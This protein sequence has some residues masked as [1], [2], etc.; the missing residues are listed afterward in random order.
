VCPSPPTR[1]LQ[2][3]ILS[4]LL[5]LWN[6]GANAQLQTGNLYGTVVDE[7]NVSLP[8]VTL[9][10]KDGG[11]PQVQVSNSQGQ[12]RFLS[13]PP[14]SYYLKAE[15]EGYSTI[16]YPN[17]SISVGQNTVIK[18]TLSAAVEDVITVTAE[19]PLLDERRIGT[20]ETVNQSE[21]EKIPTARDPWAILQSTPGVLT[22]RIN[23][24]GNESGQ[25][26]QYVG[27]GSSGDQAIWSLDGMV[28]TDIEALGSPPAYSFDSFEEIQA[29]TGGGDITTASGGVVLNLVTKRGTNEWRGTSR[30]DLLDDRF[31]SD[32]AAE[33][34]E[35]F[36]HA[37]RVVRIR[38]F[39]GELGGPLLR[40]RLWIWSSYN[41]RDSNL[42]TAAGPGALE[43]AK[44]SSDVETIHLKLNAQI[45]PAN[46]G[47]LA[48]QDNEQERSGRGAGATRPQ[49]TAWNQ[50]EAGREPTAWK[51]EDTHLFGSTLYATVFYAAV[52]NGFQLVPQG[53]LDRT[54]YLDQDALWH[55]SFLFYRTERPQEQLRADTAAFFNTGPLSHEVKLGVESREAEETSRSSWPGG[56]LLY[57]G[58]SFFD[59]PGN[60]LALSRPALLSVSLE[61]TSA[62]AQDTLN[63]GRLTASLGLRYDL[64]EARNRAGTSP[65]NPLRPDLLPAIAY[66]GG[67][68]APRWESIVPRLGLTYALGEARKTL[69]RG[70]YSHFA[71]QMGS[72]VASWVNPL[73]SQSYAYISAPSRGTEGLR[74]EPPALFYSP[75]VDPRN[76]QLLQSNAL[77]DGLR[78]PRTEEI[79]LVVEHA[80]QPEFV[81]GLS[82]TQRRLT[83]LLERELLVFDTPDPY[84]PDC[85][86]S[87][88][89]PHRRS[90]YQAR[91]VITT[92]PDGRRVPLTSYQLRPG[93]ST[94]L[95]TMLENGGREQKYRGAT[96][97]L[98]KRL[99]NR[100]LLRGNLTWSDW[101]W[102]RVPDGEVEDLTRTHPGRV[103]RRGSREGDPVLQGPED[104]DL[105]DGAYIHSGWSYNLRGLYEIAPDR[106]WGFN[107]GFNLSGRQGYPV[108]F[109]ALVTLPE[110]MQ[111]ERVRVQAAGRPDSFRLDDLHTLD[112]RLDKEFVFGDFGLTLG[113]DVF[114]ATNEATVLQRQPR[115]EIGTSGQALKVLSPRVLQLGVRFSFR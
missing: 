90:D 86:G 102:S 6:T 63:I 78:P 111:R 26:S 76:G 69:L 31:Q 62:Y 93:L 68:P 49:E 25:Q 59:T 20:G 16:D 74:A 98:N 113:V 83:R 5:L 114:N 50:S 70:S 75:N 51:L 65:A 87:V 43:G 32:S 27:P 110:N 15:L 14:G 29:T 46:W 44:D 106:P 21:L 112:L 33:D 2:G 54:A 11:A 24:G 97:V 38:D 9:T 79:L 104:P 23:V 64:Q 82:L 91:T 36:L 101:E 58:P 61:Q 22:D 41:Q 85:L 45:T 72:A 13:L 35:R 3:L 4:G 89:R 10:L 56:G 71:D 28:V 95:G 80:L 99:S 92:L 1:F 18:I 57:N 39:G 40:D 108:P 96:L 105:E 48:A 8:G 94:R 52:N 19:S 42:R 115:L 107:A 30:F 66:G 81:V 88:G 77:A 73:A 84:C 67:D 60:V 55:D 103:P 109:F 47:T 12:F 53:G 7:E 17:I 100:W 34:S 37:N